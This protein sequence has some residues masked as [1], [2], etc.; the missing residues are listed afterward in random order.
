MNWILLVLKVLIAF[1]GVGVT[2]YGAN[3]NL[4]G[5]VGAGFGGALTYLL[6]SPLKR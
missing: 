6:Q 2:A 1:L 5:A 4:L 3:P